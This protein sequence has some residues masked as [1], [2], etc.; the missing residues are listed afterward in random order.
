MNTAHLSRRL[1]LMGM[2]ATGV[3]GVAACSGQTDEDSRGSSTAQKLRLSVQAPPSNFSVGNWSGGDATL[4]LSVY[5]TVVMSG[6][7]GEIEPAI[8][9]SW[10][11][12]EARTT[13]TFTIRQGMKFSDGTPVDAAAVA[14]SLEVARKGSSTSQNYAAVAAVEAPDAS[15]V[16]VTLSQ[17]DAA[18]LPMLSGTPGA[19]GSTAVLAAESSKL[20]PV[21]SGPYTL[22][23][24]A[25][26]PGAT[27]V[28]QRNPD[29]WNVDSYPYPTVQIQVIADST[30]AQ[31]AVQAGQLDYTGLTS[32]DLAKRF[33]ASRFTTGT[34]KSN[35]VGALFLVDRTGKIVP[36][37]ADIRVRQAINLAI[38]R[39]SIA[40]SINPGTNH[41][42]AQM[43]SPNGEAYDET[44]DDRY[45]YDP[46]KAKSL[47][48]EAGFA[49]G[50]EVTM[51]STVVSTTYESVITQALADIGIAVTWETVPF[52]DFYPKV[53]GGSYGMFFMFNGFSVS[54]AVD[55]NAILS[56]VFN[57]FMDAPLELQSLRQAAD[58][59]PS[60]SQ[61]EAFRAVNSYLVEQAWYAPI[62]YLT[63][64]YVVPKT[65]E[66]TPPI[67]F[68]QSVLP[69]QPAQGA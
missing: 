29:H 25:T 28:L 44:F 52:Q 57:P 55:L 7:D 51:P 49:D 63:G 40:E 48:A 8:A 26:T 53:F 13:L 45:A 65:I 22:D 62:S 27:Y 67:A 19:V 69:F 56:G 17:P 43:F 9:E 11:Y 42:T 21:G 46:A 1:V 36:A 23:A 61:G 3:A 2:A 33:D 66:Y 5:D 10:N 20:Q 38:D 50:F 4:F 34:G 60:D 24:D 47:L 15:T 59:A 39:Q 41:P 37:L 68:G 12:D 18:F 14:A 58:S 35:T 54:D 16:V 30:A 32:A 31:N 6:M 64:F